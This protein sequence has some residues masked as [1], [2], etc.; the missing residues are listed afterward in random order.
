MKINKISILFLTLFLVNTACQ[1]IQEGITGTK[2]SK[3]SDEFFVK[4]KNPLILPPDYDE[5][6][7]PKQTGKDKEVEEES[8][9]RILGVSSKNEQA[10]VIENNNRSLEENILEKIKKK[11]E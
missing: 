9:K 11:A 5:L 8:I 1:S 4:K 2:R 3:S 7:K 10:Q 6:P